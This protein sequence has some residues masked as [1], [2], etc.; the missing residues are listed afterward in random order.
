MKIGIVGPGAIGLLYTFYLQKSNQNVT[1]FTRTAKQAEELNETGVT[2]IRDR[3]CETV[4]PSVLPIESMVAQNLDYIFIAVKQYHID[5]ILPFVEGAAS[6]I[7]LQNGMS[8]LQKML[9]IGCENIAVGI[10]EHGAKKEGGHIV[11]HTGVGVTKFGVVCGQS[12]HFESVFHS[13]PVSY[14]PVQIE[15]DWKEIM[16]KK[17]VVNVCINPLTALLGVKNGELTKNRFFYQMME[18]VF[19]EVAFLIRGEKEMVWQMV[20]NVCEGTSRNTS[21]M[22]A[23]VRANRQTEINAIVGYVLEEAKKQQRPV[24][25]LQFLLDAIKGLETRV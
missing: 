13:F 16:H 15:T 4:Y 18:Q 9:N 20:R 12:I 21:S 3:T 2:C 11:H 22:L 25:T 14:F 5:D 6:L 17:L 8:H 1:L 10:V 23:D 7:F 24:P 19:Q